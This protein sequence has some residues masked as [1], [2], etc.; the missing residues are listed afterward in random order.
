MDTKNSEIITIDGPTSSGKNSVAHLFCK[1]IGY[2]FIDSGSIFRCFSIAFLK[3]GIKF[4][5]DEKIEKLLRTLEVNFNGEKVILNGEDVSE[6]LHNS[7]VTA[8]VPDIAAKKYVREIATLTQRRVVKGK[9]TVMVG[10]DLGSEIFP[11]AKLKFYLTADPEVR[12]RRRYNQ[13][14]KKDLNITYEEVFKQLM[15][16][17]TKDMTRKVSP[18]RIPEGAVII[19]TTN[20]TA[21]QSV[22]EFMK[23][24]LQGYS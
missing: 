7:E 4:E 17:D 10:R 13:L 2:Q 18:L 15:E 21:E 6:D 14:I 5:D 12:A 23:H 22:E 11:K 1:K 8:V 16:R 3:S 20:L 24:F 19:D 9:N